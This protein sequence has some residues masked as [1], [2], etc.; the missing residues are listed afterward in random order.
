MSTSTIMAKK[1]TSCALKETLQSVYKKKSCSSELI[2]FN[3]AIV[4]YKDE[5][6]RADNLSYQHLQLGVDWTLLHR[7]W[8]SKN[9]S[10]HLNFSRVSR[11]VGKFF[12]QPSPTTRR[13]TV[14]EAIR[15]VLSEELRRKLMGLTIDDSAKAQFSGGMTQRA[16]R[17]HNRP[18]WRNDRQRLKSRML[19]TYCV[20]ERPAILSPIVGR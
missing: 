3:S 19:N 11:W 4:Q 2:L 14:D 7:A 6:D 16:G 10:R 8:I 20:Q 17:D 1:E 13:L 9:K 5:R 15:V 12:V 18:R